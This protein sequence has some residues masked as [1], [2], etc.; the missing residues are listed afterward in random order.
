MYN[1]VFVYEG[2][3]YYGMLMWVPQDAAG[4]KVVPDG[5]AA[6]TVCA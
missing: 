2:Y 5:S 6:D 3:G 1:V 4:G